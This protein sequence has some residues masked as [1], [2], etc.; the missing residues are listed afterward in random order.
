[1]GPAIDKSRPNVMADV[2]PDLP[3]VTLVS[4]L[5]IEGK[6]PVSKVDVNEVP[7][8]SITKAP[9]PP[10]EEVPMLGASFWIFNVPAEMVVVP[11]YVLAPDNVSVPL[12]TLVI[13]T[14][15]VLPS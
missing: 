12:P 6:L 15:A 9:E 8:D 13:A 14:F 10:I 3:I 7:E 2:L 5:P 4:E 1:M 11:V